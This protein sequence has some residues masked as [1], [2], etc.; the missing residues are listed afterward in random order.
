MPKR[1][2]LLFVCCVILTAAISLPAQNAA[3]KNTSAA[4]DERIRRIENGIPPIP[5]GPGQPPLQLT[6]QQLMDAFKVPG[7][8]V[9][10]V[11]NFKIAWA[12]PYGVTEAGTDQPSYNHAPC[13]RQLPSASL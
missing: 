1:F 11:D 6:L 12:K 7:L 5:L 2:L 4:V 8:S 10:V 9:A 3:P 13:F